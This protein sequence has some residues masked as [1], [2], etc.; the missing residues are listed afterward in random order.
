MRISSKDSH[1]ENGS[2]LINKLNL[3]TASFT[4]LLSLI[5]IFTFKFALSSFVNY[6]RTAF[7]LSI[8]FITIFPLISAIKYKLNPLK[9]VKN[10]LGFDSVF[11]ALIIIFN[12]TLITFA[13]NL[14]FNV[15]FSNLSVIAFTL[16][17]P[18]I[19]YLLIVIHFILKCF[20]VKSLKRRF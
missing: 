1:V 16:I 3:L 9:T 20:I 4:F 19:A 15:D 11:V 14:L 7:L 6:D 2:L 10:N 18:L 12:L 5:A 17:L 13:L 8:L